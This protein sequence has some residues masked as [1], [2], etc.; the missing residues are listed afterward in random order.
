MSFSEK[1]QKLRKANKLSQEQLAAML[2][3]TRQS[4]SKWESAQTYPEMDKLLA[5]CKIFKCSLDDL[6][7]EEITD[8]G[9]EE[10]KKMNINTVIDSALDFINRAYTMFRSME[11]GQIIQCIFVMFCVAMA[12]LLCRLP[13]TMLEDSFY[14]IFVNVSNETFVHLLSGIFNLIVDV[15][16]FVLF[17]LL[18][19][20]IFKIAYLDNAKKY[21]PLTSEESKEQNTSDTAKAPLNTTYK[22]TSQPKNYAIFTALGAIAMAFIKFIVACFSFPFIAALFFLCA[23]LLILLFLLFKGVFYF[24][25]ILGAIFGIIFV[26]FVLEIVFSFLFNRQMK[27]KRLLLTFLISIAGMG[28][29]FGLLMVDVANTSYIDTVPTSIKSSTVEKEVPM[30]E[31]LYFYNDDIK[32]VVDNQLGNNVKVQTTYYKDYVRV[33]THDEDVTLVVPISQSTNLTNKKLFDLIIH[34]LA[35]KKLYNYGK[36]YELEITVFASESNLQIIKQN[37]LKMK[38]EEAEERRKQRESYDYEFS[39]YQRR[40]ETLEA[41]NQSLQEKN[42]TL[43]DSL[44]EY[45]NKLE[46]YKNSLQSI[47]EE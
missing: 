42:Q 35:Q 31:D 3:V 46:E 47:I 1:L 23:G 9:I 12:L 5:M 27:L 11:V 14:D 8:V 19:G 15:G 44:E 26:I 20:Y 17:I 36:L 28:L 37:Y 25:V 33:A 2:D 10:K 30:R 13:F 32:Y 34:D 43:E 45:R 29:S 41:E 4:V 39:E 16:Y 40:I 21:L 7:N 18:F 6:T 22:E 24:S 38:A